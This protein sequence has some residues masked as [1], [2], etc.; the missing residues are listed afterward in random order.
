MC[1]I[2]VRKG[3]QASPSLCVSPSHDVWERVPGLRAVLR[4]QHW[5]GGA[6][7]RAVTLGPSGSL[8]VCLPRVAAAAA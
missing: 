5:A 7:A 4:A 3:A 2:R 8:F 1:A 6:D